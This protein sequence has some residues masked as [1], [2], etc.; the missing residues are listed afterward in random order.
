MN[1]SVNFNTRICEM[2]TKVFNFLIF[3]SA[4][5]MLAVLTGIV[6]WTRHTHH[7][8]HQNVI[9][10]TD[11]AMTKSADD[12][13]R[14]IE[15]M[16]PKMDNG[17]S[18]RTGCNILDPHHIGGVTP[19]LDSILIKE[20]LS[21]HIDARFAYA[22]FQNGE[23]IYRSDSTIAE[24]AYSESINSKHLFCGNAGHNLKLSVVFPDGLKQSEQARHVSVWW[25][26]S[27]AGSVV[28]M[29]TGFMLFRGFSMIKRDT[30]RRTSIINNL[31][32][33]FKTPIA[34]IKLGAEMLLNEAVINER[35]RV[36]RYAE[37]I[38]FE[39]Q[40]LQFNVDQILN[41]VLLDEGQIM[42][43]FKYFSMNAMI[44]EIIEKF[45]TVRDELKSRIKL[46]LHASDDIIYA[47]P[48]H[49]INVITNLLE[50]S[51][52]Y[53]GEQVEISIATG[54][55]GGSRLI[56]FADNGPGI[57]KKYQRLVFERYFR[58][59]PGNRHDIKGHGIG[60]YYVK[61]ILA[62]MGAN[63]LLVSHNGRGARFE[64]I[65]PDETITH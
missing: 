28:I 45:L 59:N 3:I 9:T 8:V 20:F 39:N 63:I 35:E 55:R 34:S 43:R 7:V 13:T 12:F 18:S 53:G 21:C 19:I 51:L 30:L 52:K 37:L 48:S 32:H 50:N 17:D 11:V 56:M 27:I 60:L 47:D 4:V 61:N 31:A 62:K 36:H 46:E 24:R 44:Q 65:F 26:I 40:R 57:P 33:E 41:I 6:V 25:I 64:I 2:N 15:K 29:I 14:V 10:L 38:R 5:A 54:N 1:S 42:L 16:N 22:L 49:F 58:I 23:M